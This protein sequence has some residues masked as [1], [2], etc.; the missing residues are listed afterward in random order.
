MVSSYTGSTCGS[1]WPRTLVCGR[2]IVR[3]IGISVCVCVF[4]CVRVRVR[5]R[6]RVCV[7]IKRAVREGIMIINTV[8]MKLRK[9]DMGPDNEHRGERE[10]NKSIRME[11]N[12]TRKHNRL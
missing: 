5:V 7:C 3:D 4:V 6:V 9:R 10:D 1:G 12:S 2:Y 11:D 8:C